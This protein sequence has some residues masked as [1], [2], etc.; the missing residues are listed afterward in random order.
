MCLAL[1]STEENELPSD[2]YASHITS[3]KSK[4][5][6]RFASLDHRTEMVPFLIFEYIEIRYHMEAKRLKN[7]I[8][9]KLKEEQHKLRK[10][11]KIKNSKAT[12]FPIVHNVLEGNVMTDPD[13]QRP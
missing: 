2:F 5:F 4:G 10:L 9:Q 12:I 3:L 8:S 1:L 7:E 13:S 6:L 11:S